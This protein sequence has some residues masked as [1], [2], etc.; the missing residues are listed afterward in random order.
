MDESVQQRQAQMLGNRVRKNARHLRKWARRE[1]VSCYRVYDRDIPEV[2]LAIDWYE[3]RLHVA[4]YRRTADVDATEEELLVWT[5]AMAVAAADALGVTDRGRIH[6][7][8]RR[9]QRGG[10]QH[11][12]LE[13]D[14]EAVIVT[15]AGLSLE[16]NLEGYL[17]TGLFLDHRPL[18]VRVGAEARGKRVLN[19]FC[20][21]GAFTVHAAAGGAL[22]TTSVDLSK[23][24]LAWARR[25]LEL[26][27]L[28]ASRH[29]LVHDDVRAFLGEA[30]RR[31]RRFELIVLDPPTFSNSKRTEEDLDL[32]RDHVALV[33]DT[34]ALLAPEGI[35][36]FSTNNRRFKLDEGALTGLQ[37]ENISLETI[38]P[39]FRDQRI[40]RCWR[41]RR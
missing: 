28:Y 37:L 21:T 30:R 10:V 13:E 38:P 23:T 35:L 6:V 31:G 8:E 4:R 3:G 5:E 32:Q 9:R 22:Q 25:N 11:R 12:R 36:Y 29:E 14:A 26:N 41:I 34:A 20:Y 39:D 7:K 17:D 33:T 15:E 19:L 18:R 1:A 2:P 40:H 16:V 27:G 24:Y